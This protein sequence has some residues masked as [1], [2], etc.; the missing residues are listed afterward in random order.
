MRVALETVTP[1]AA[2]PNWSPEMGLL[3][4]ATLDAILRPEVLTAP[5][6]CD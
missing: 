3:E 5:H 1:A 4:R 6:S 2:S